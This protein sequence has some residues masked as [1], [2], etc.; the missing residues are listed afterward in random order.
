MSE[1]EI[2]VKLSPYDYDLIGEIST[3]LGMSVPEALQHCIN[4]TYVRVCCNEEGG[5]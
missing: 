1:I 4:A 5:E 3:K 2:K